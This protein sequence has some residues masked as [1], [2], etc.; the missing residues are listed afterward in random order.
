VDCADVAAVGA[1]VL[2][3]DG[4]EGRTYLVTGTEAL[5]MAGVA[6]HVSW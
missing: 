3:Q 5:S 2:T 4:H 6:A 1:A